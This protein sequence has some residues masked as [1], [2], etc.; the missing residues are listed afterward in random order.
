MGRRIIWSHT[1]ATDVE[2]IME[3]LRHSSP[4]YSKQFILKVRTAAKNLK[5]FPERGRHIPEYSDSDLREIFVD[6]FRLFYRVSAEEV[7]I[8]G[9]VHMARDISQL[10]VSD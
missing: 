5:T 1:A 9:V 4:F 8:V 10:L 2:A 6:S 7:E 3:Y